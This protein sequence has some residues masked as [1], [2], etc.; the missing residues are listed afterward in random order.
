MRSHK[1][2]LFALGLNE[3]GTI[4]PDGVRWSSPADITGIPE[5][6]DE[7]DTTNFAGITTLGGDG[8]NI[9]DGVSLRDSFVVYRESGITVFDYVGGQF[10]WK[11]MSRELSMS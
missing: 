2:F 9:I 8:G 7:L 1:Q 5:T 11:S 6:W 3:G 10:V 4:I